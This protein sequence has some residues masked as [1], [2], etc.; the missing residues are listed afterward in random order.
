MA[1]LLSVLLRPRSAMVLLMRP[2]G[3]CNNKMF[4]FILGGDIKS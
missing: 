1:R 3:V 2:M 4:L